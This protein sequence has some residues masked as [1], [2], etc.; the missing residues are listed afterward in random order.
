MSKILLA[1]L[2]FSSF[3]IKAQNQKK[4][5]APQL[6]KAAIKEVIAAMT[7]DEKVSFVSGIGMSGGAGTGIPVVGNIVGKVP[8]SAGSTL[9]IPRLGIPAVIWADGPAGVRIDTLRNNDEKRYYSTAFPIGTSLASTWNTELVTRVG[10]AMANEAL[11]YGIDVLLCPGINIQRNP[12]CGRNYEYYS[13]DPVV[14]GSIAT[15]MVNGIQSQGVGTSVKHFAVNNQESNRNNVDAIISERALRETYLKGFEIVVNQAHPWTIMS[16]YNKVNGQ[17]TSESYDLL[18][19]ILRNEWNFKGM[20]VTD[21]YAGRN[22]VA[23]VN[24]GND[25][26]MPGRKPETVQLNEALKNGTLKLETLDKNIERILDLIEKSPS[27]KNYKYS[28][29][30]NLFEN[31]KVS[32]EAGAEGIVLLKNENK[33]LPISASNK[34]ALLGNASYDLFIGGTGSGEVYKAY[35]VSLLQGLKNSGYGV[36]NKLK[37]SYQNY[38]EKEKSLRPKRNNI[39]QKIKPFQEMNV[40]SEELTRLANSSEIA[41]I[42]IGRNAGEGSDRKLESDYY[43]T[44]EEIK[45]IENTAKAFHSQGKKVIVVL[46]IDAVVDVARWRD[47]VDG[48]LL[49]WLPG[50]EAGNSITDVLSGN[51]NPSGHLAI[52]FPNNYNDVPSS[53]SFPGIPSERPLTSVYDDGIY[54]GYR[55]YSKFKVKPAYEFGYGLSYTDFSISNVE[56]SSKDFSNAIIVTM[57]VKNT[58]KVAG[59]EVVQLYL[60]APAKTMN[61]PES[62][63]KAFAKTNLL[64]PGEG[65]RI[66]FTINASDL[67]SFDSERS[68]WIAEPGKYSI[69]IGNSSLNILQTKSFELN[70]ELVVKKVNKVLTP[71]Q[72]IDGL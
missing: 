29:T 35:S 64:H 37:E 51:V 56:L 14:S 19:T 11:E 70:S 7:Q 48:I 71:T 65:Q 66:A 10:R 38:I 36:D 54:V 43:F 63:L 31:A 3:A 72:I 1:V 5:D 67:A 57:N 45:L 69:K 30:P 32:R 39:L 28:N 40:T 50:Q 4:N 25:L 49:A 55:F 41:L 53:K 22:Y 12:L 59:K 23:Q 34:I 62:E 6:G 8:G 42:T 16:S 52:N 9:A 44:P 60:S 58:G 13:E 27:F 18:T 61:K 2:V 21:W 26:L 17:Y 24:A 46:N 47:N 68:A 33:A 20:V 15:A